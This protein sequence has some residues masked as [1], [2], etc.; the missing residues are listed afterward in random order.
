MIFNMVTFDEFKKF[1]IRVG[2]IL[3]V[4][5]LINAQYTT[6]KITVDFG[7]GIGTKVSGARLINYSEKELIGKQIVGLINLPPRQIG[8]IMSEFLTLGTPDNHN[9]CILLVPEKNVPLGGA[10]Y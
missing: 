2:K 7:N 10:V 4:E 8:K 6:H 9:E 1:E 3:A 5:Q